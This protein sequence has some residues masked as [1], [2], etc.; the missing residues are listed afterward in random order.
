MTIFYFTG[1]G[2]SL[3]V[4]KRIGGTLISIPQVIDS[5][6]QYY[7]DEVIG[8]VFP[9]YWA[10]APDMVQE[11][12]QKA[13]F[14]CDYLFLI[15]T[16][17]GM[18]CASLQ[19]MQKL[20]KQNGCQFNYLDTVDMIDNSMSTG[21]IERQISKL[22]KENFELKM[23]MIQ[24]NITERKQNP[25]KKVNIFTNAFSFLVS[26][27]PNYE[28]MPQKLSV[29]A[30]CNLCKI[31]VKT[32]PAGNIEVND[33]VYFGKRCTGCLACVHNCPKNAI[34]FKWGRGSSR[35]RHPEVSLNE[36]IDSNNRNR[37]SPLDT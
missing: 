37:T 35:W 7:N 11:F 17:G 2:N 1:T 3:A 24:K 32:C 25:D 10:T 34:H 13:K 12:I 21:S 6:D 8:V 5:N 20:A 31:C 15:A 36:I 33:N 9:V 27:I 30:K 28:K 19:I 22:S 4:A 16:S 29:D 23:A 14:E 18:P 26:R